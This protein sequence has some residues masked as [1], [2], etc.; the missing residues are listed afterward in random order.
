MRYDIVMLVSMKVVVFNTEGNMLALRRSET[1]PVRPFG[2]D[3]PG[4]RLEEGEDLENGIKRE[5]L[6]ESGLALDAVT[7]VDAVAGYNARKEFWVTIGYRAIVDAPEV[8]LS[9]EHD[10]YEWISKEEF[11]ARESTEKIKR[12]VSKA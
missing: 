10:K 6:E 7:L 5:T 8:I 12:L 4:G 9:Y 1:D 2:W 11:L 3:I